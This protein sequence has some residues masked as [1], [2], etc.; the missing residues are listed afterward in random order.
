MKRWTVLVV[1]AGCAGEKEPMEPH[2]RLL[3]E[4]FY[5]SGAVPAAGLDRYY[6]DQFIQLVNASDEPVLA[7]GLQIANAHGVAGEINPGTQPDSYASSRP[8][9]VVLESVW[10]IPGAPEDLVIQPGEGL[11][12]AH[13]GT[14]HQP[15]STLDL[16]GADFET[17]VDVYEGGDDDHV[18]V[19]NLESVHYTGGYD[20]LVP[21]FGASIVVMDAEAEVRALDGTNLW[22]LVSVSVEHVVDGVDAVMDGASGAYKRLPDTVDTGFTYVSDTYTGE[23][24]RRVRIDGVYQDTNDS[25]VDFEVLS[26]PEPY[27]L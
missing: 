14:N 13:D 9:R 26:E 5:Y 1:L 8:N 24:V 19:E 12:L 4:E 21:V 11:L 6:S 20:W 10:R 2:G 23:S 16:T 25:S 18:G 7:G 15:M 27:G 3:I 17:Y 22:D